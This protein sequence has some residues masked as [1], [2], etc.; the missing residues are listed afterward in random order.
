[1]SNLT[2]HEGSARS[3]SKTGGNR[4]SME[5]RR[6]FLKRAGKAAVYAPPT[7][8]LLSSPSYAKIRVSCGD[9]KACKDFQQSL[10]NGGKDHDSDNNITEKLQN[11]LGGIFG[12]FGF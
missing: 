11:M 9:S 8:M 3:V 1:M 10:K 7:I 6:A 12:G 5:A 4:V 2:K